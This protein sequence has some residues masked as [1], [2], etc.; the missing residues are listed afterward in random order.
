MIA[1]RQS[2]PMMMR[3]P[4]KT[5]AKIIVAHGDDDGSFSNPVRIGPELK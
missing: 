5:N 2:K 1:M 3:I 4:A